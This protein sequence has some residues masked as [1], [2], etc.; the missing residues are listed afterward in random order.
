MKRLFLGV[1]ALMM[2]AVP[3]WGQ[4]T[5]RDQA[6]AGAAAHRE[7]MNNNPNRPHNRHKRHH[8]HHRHH[9]GT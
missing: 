6:K 4:G 1:F 9:N 8:R 2:L 3:G 5:A 7:E